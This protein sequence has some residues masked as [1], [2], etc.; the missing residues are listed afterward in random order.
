M[1]GAGAVIAFVVGAVAGA[2]HDSA[3]RELAAS[4]AAAWERGDYAQMHALLAEPERSRINLRRFTR[5]YARAASTATATGVQAGEARGPEEGVVVVPMS[6][7]TRI[8]GTVDG[9]LRLEIGERAD[10]SPGVSWR[11]E[12]VFPGLRPGERLTRETRMPRRGT[13]QARDGTPIA[14]GEARLSKLDPLASEIAGRVGPAP[15]E[16]GDALAARGVPEGAPV[17]LTGL[18]RQFDARLSGVPGGVLLAGDRGLASSRAQRGENVRTTIDPDIQRA[19][20]QALAGR[21]GGIAAVRP[22]TGEVLGLAGIAFSA[23]QPPGSVFKIVTLAGALEE[24]IVKRSDSFPVQTAATLEGVEL[25]NAHGESCG[26]SLRNS[27]AKSC[28]SVFAPMGAELGAERLVKTAES[29]GF[30][31]EPALIGAAR[32]TIPAAGEIGD[33][34]AVGSSAIGQGKVLTT[35]LQMALIAAAIGERGRRVQPTLLRGSQGQAMQA[36]P[37]RVARTVANYMRAVVTDGTG[38]G[39]AIPGVKVAGKTG[40]AELRSTVSEDPVPLEPGEPPPEE[41]LTDTDA[42]FTAFAP[43]RNPEIAVCVLLV[44]QGAGGETAAPAAKAVIQ[45]AL[46]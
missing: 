36:T 45:E 30:N 4:F 43:M 29:F 9:E 37:P 18:E 44:S 13:I 24:G 33:D 5:A 2:R 27:F 23:P 32:S 7:R 46:S 21:Y 12:Y 42:W 39:A 1:L 22:R 15:P 8:F 6:A 20:V 11:P 25:K 41:D 34:L 38:A 40:T 14:Q 3:E 17:G 16:L 10:G 31:E 28:N 35:P 19:A 26:G